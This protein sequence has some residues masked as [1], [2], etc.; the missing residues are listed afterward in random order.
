MTS[1][2]GSD[3]EGGHKSDGEDEH[4]NL[5]EWIKHLFDGEDSSED[6]DGEEEDVDDGD[7][8]HVFIYLFNPKK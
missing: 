2:S 1:Y 6:G 8:V 4:F 7:H 5:W 3:G